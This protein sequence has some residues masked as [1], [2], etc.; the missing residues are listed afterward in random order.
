[1]ELLVVTLAQIN[2]AREADALARMRIIS[3]TVRNAPGLLNARFYRSREP[4][5]SYCMLTTWESAEW[6]QK[7]QE[8]HAPRTLLLASPPGIF[9]TPPD[10]WLMQYLWGYSRPLAQPAVAAAHLALV[11]PEMAERVQHEWLESLRQQAIEPV[12]SFALLARS[13]EEEPATAA[14]L[15]VSPLPQG[16]TQEAHRQ[17]SRQGTMFFNLL[18]WPGERYREDFY[19]NEISQ[20]VRGLLNR[21]AMVHVLTLDPM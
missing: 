1:M 8:R 12:L 7:A 4:G 17:P 19:A 11:R 10:Q 21:T 14:P 6:W 13:I 15:P 5:T 9:H 18:S 16:Q 20:N 2:S 3:D